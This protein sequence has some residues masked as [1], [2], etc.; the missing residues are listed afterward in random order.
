M[1]TID[2]MNSEVLRLER[3][4]EYPAAA[5]LALDTAIAAW[6]KYDKPLAAEMLH[7]VIRLV[8]IV[9][10]IPN[11]IDRQQFLANA[12]LLQA[13]IYLFCCTFNDALN[14]AAEAHTH[15]EKLHEW[16]KCVETL[17]IS[18]DVC[19][20]QGKYGISDEYAHKAL[21]LAQSNG[22]TYGESLA[23]TVI[24]KTYHALGENDEAMESFKHCLDISESLDDDCGIATALCNLGMIHRD[25]GEY[26]LGLEFHTRSLEIIETSH[27]PKLMGAV[28]TGIGDIYESL[29][30]FD[31]AQSHYTRSV[32]I[33]E[34]LGDINSLVQA[35]Q[36][37]AT[38]LANH[39]SYNEA[40][41]SLKRC[42][43]LRET[44]GNQYN[45][46]QTYALFGECYKKQ[47]NLLLAQ[48]ELE[49]ALAIAQ[50][51]QSTR[52][53]CAI[54]K[55]L[56]L[57]H[58]STGEMELAFLHHL[59]YSEY[60]ESIFNEDADKRI[61]IMQV[62]LDVKRTMRDAENERMRS[63]QLNSLNL[64][65]SQFF[66]NLSH[67]FRTPLTLILGP[68][69]HIIENTA[70]PETRSFALM[71]QRN[72]SRMLELIN[73]L[74]ELAKSE[75]GAMALIASK[76]NLT[77]T[78]RRI[79]MLF[80]SRADDKCI[81]YIIHIP[82]EPLDAYFDKKKIESVM[83][84]ILSNAFKFTPNDGSITV[85][86]TCS[87]QTDDYVNGCAKIIITDTGPGIP[88]T[89]LPFVFNRF[90]QLNSSNAHP[91]E[92]TGIGLALAK[93]LIELHHGQIDAASEVGKGTKFTIIL[94][95][96]RSHLR[97]NEII[98]FPKDD[99]PA[100]K[101][102]NE[103]FIATND[104][105]APSGRKNPPG[106][107]STTDKRPIVLIVDD[108]TDVRAYIKDIIGK[109]Y[110]VWEA[111]NGT[112]GARI[113][114]D[115]IPDIIISDV[116]MPNKDGFTLCRELK[117]DV[118]TSHIPVILLTAKTE[119]A[120]KLS[121]LEMGADDYLVKPFDSQELCA[122]IKN[123]LEQRRR[124]RESFRIN[125]LV[126]PDGASPVSF[127]FIDDKFLQS[128]YRVIETNI[129]N[130]KFDVDSLCREC[131]VSRSQMHR[132]IHALTNYSAG[133]LIRFVRLERAMTML[134]QGTDNVAEVGYA[135]GFS[136]P[137]YFTKCFHD[138]FGVLPSKVR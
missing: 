127:T 77:D 69:T 12:L 55:S 75:S 29:G 73:Q 111:E 104:P 8:R 136:N 71:I 32:S 114:Q 115:F 95:L 82:D 10:A 107:Y 49:R 119:S 3:D 97:E 28:L 60:K 42:L 4:G 13:K 35:L 34:S 27:D 1:N 137:S 14:S 25:L 92:G 31:K 17:T 128:I 88:E 93:D 22:D 62:Q 138:R 122:R 80:Q 130:D 64:S 84:N 117:L 36:G 44:I 98:E 26:F 106:R 18:A 9:D 99:P 132:K 6:K 113:A 125:N 24:G 120:S 70:E 50:N 86:L 46:A 100:E 57:L 116:I 61:R 108:N 30:V 52:L 43:E 109:D 15:F 89:A 23:L 112:E 76:Y 85:Q 16:Q 37:F 134:K 79:S 2:A 121:G 94:P 5:K 40:L 131:A 7:L 41:A 51:L 59:K 54:H 101:T 133:E 67:E 110:N 81:L 118:R 66:S 74:L 72:G 19:Q 21:R 78:V 87:E 96:G 48:T 11:E 83:V 124:L 90:Y 135:V 56:F 68:V 105:S 20:V 126:K 65:K 39:N 53:Q 91:Y 58:E 123:L 63:E 102:S 103:F 45:I 47:G 38:M 129:G 33:F